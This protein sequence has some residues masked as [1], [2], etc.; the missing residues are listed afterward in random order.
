MILWVQIGP[1]TE[2]PV[3]QVLQAPRGTQNVPFLTAL[4]HTREV[5]GAEGGIS[6]HTSRATSMEGEVQM[7]QPPAIN[8]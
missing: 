1:A 6:H 3:P 8:S 7:T 4:V 2:A 5:L